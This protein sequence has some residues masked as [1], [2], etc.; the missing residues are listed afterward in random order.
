[1][2]ALLKVQLPGSGDQEPSNGTFE[3]PISSRAGELMSETEDPAI[4]SSRT[5]IANPIQ[6]IC[7]PARLFRL[8]L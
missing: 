5:N 8:S 1:M 7:L 2:A 3:T 4:A 6:I